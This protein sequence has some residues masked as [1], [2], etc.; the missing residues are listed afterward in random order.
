MTARYALR[1]LLVAFVVLMVQSTV[2]LSV[3]I[4]GVHPDLLWLLPITAALLDGPE[5]GA[6]V[7]FWSGLAFDLTLPTPFGLSALV[8]CVLGFSMG[9]ATAAVDKRA[10]WLKPV[11]ALF[12][13]VVADML[14]AVLGAVLGQQQMVQINFLSLFLVVALSSVVL[15]LPVNRFMRWALLP[16]GGDRRSLVSAQS[17]DGGLW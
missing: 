1:W 8:G 10:V 5:T 6:L 7:G 16:G 13:S 14:F 15:V 3:R 2:M 12:G 4:G 17:P 11:A 9:M